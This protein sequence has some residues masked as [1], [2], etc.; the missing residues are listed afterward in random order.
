MFGIEGVF[1]NRVVTADWQVITHDDFHL[2]AD[3]V[4]PGATIA[5]I[6]AGFGTHSGTPRQIRQLSLAQL[7][8]Q[9]CS[10][11]VQVSVIVWVVIVALTSNTIS[12][13]CSH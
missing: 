13:H 5:S 7:S 9:K 12:P 1:A 4:T 8:E 10:F 11:S 3:C 2:W 6:E